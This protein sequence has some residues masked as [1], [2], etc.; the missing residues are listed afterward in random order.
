MPYITFAAILLISVSA[1]FSLYFVLRA[2]ILNNKRQ[3]GTEPCYGG[4]AF[5]G[6]NSFKH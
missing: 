3:I 5:G 1:M 4:A 6:K 2:Y